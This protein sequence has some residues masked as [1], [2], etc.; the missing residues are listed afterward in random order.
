MPT[1]RHVD[2]MMP[3]IEKLR[4]REAVRREQRV[5]R[6]VNGDGTLNLPKNMDLGSAWNGRHPVMGN[7]HLWIDPAGKLRIKNGAPTSATDGTVV[8]GQT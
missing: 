3:A 2:Q 1:E 5:D 6:A 7:H 8:G 4:G